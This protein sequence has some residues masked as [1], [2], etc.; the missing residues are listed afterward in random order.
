MTTA[1]HSAGNNGELESGDGVQ[2]SFS[3]VLGW[4]GWQVTHPLHISALL[5]LK[6]KNNIF[7][8]D[9]KNL[10]SEIM[11]VRPLFKTS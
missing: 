3:Q 11:K 6:C 9:E 2:L 4:Q 8:R 10:L 7:L 5:S 1:L